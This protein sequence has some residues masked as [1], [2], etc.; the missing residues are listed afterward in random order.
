MKSLILMLSGAGIGIAAYVLFT[1][2][3]PQSFVAAQAGA[4]GTGKRIDGVT[5]SVAGSVK[6]G[7]GKLTG[8]ESIRAEGLADKAKGAVQDAAGSIAQ[9]VSDVAAHG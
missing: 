2:N 3:S 4:W 1:Q 9:T 6:E 8:D 5:D 7:F